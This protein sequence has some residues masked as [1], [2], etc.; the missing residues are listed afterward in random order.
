VYVTAWDIGRYQDAAVAIVLDITED[1]HDLVAYR[2]LRGASYPQ[3]QREIEA[4][5]KKYP[6]IT[7]VEKNAAGAAVLENLNLPE[8]ELEGFTTTRDSKA[9][10]IQQLKLKMQQWC[11]KWN[12][13]ACPQLDADNVVQDSVMALAIAEEFA[14]KAHLRQGRVIGVWHV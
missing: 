1:V 14:T 5:H 8:H 4:L 12:A 3:I 7:A 6:G 13:E 10:I 9:R 11:I 2:R